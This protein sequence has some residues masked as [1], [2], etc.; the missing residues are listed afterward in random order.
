MTP[1]TEMKPEIL[2]PADRKKT[3]EP[4]PSRR[5]FFA[6][7]AAMLA[8]PATVAAAPAEATTDAPAPGR[9]GY[10]ETEHVR[11]YYRRANF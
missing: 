10:R 3:T 5:G 9:A 4:R 7:G 2:Q 11:A 8:A 1:D 6:A